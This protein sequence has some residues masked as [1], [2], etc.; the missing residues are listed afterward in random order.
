MRYA[1]YL[2]AVLTL[3][4]CQ[5]P[6]SAFVVRFWNH[7]D[8]YYTLSL[9]ML[10]ET[11]DVTD[12]MYLTPREDVVREY[13]RT[14]I[15]FSRLTL[16]DEDGHKRV[17]RNPLSGVSSEYCIIDIYDDSV[18]ARNWT[19]Y[20]PKDQADSKPECTHNYWQNPQ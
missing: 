20:K 17:L 3:V 19:T 5:C 7:T 2:L 15:V 6:L 8:H 12:V 14:Q 10:V 4:A 1:K 9:S 18:T 13:E 16:E 11:F